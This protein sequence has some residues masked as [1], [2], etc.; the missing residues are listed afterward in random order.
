VLPLFRT[1]KTI[2]VPYTTANVPDTITTK[3][4][5]ALSRDLK[6]VQVTLK[7]NFEQ[8]VAAGVFVTDC[9]EK[10]RIF[11]LIKTLKFKM[12]SGHAEFF[13]FKGQHLP[14]VH[15]IF[16][17]EAWFSDTLPTGAGVGAA[18]YYA[19]SIINN[20]GLPKANEK[21]WLEVTLRNCATVGEMFSAV[22]N[23]D[24]NSLEITI[25]FEYLNA[26]ESVI[27]LETNMVDHQS[28][29]TALE[30]WDSITQKRIWLATII[31]GYDNN[32]VTINQVKIEHE[33]I[34]VFELDNGYYGYLSKNVEVFNSQIL[35]ADFENCLGIINEEPFRINHTT[36]AQLKSSSAKNFDIICFYVRPEF[37]GVL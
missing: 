7:V 19:S 11:H 5:I 28:I 32:A 34:S 36:V 35:H 26:G 12:S 24:I 18:D 2:T 6:R 20:V 1:V 3:T 8:G 9:P 10:A 4:G 25:A 15:S 21:L 37:E 17:K 29:T 14:L 22:N 31:D 23:A 13:E 33:G 16:N 27:G 30:D